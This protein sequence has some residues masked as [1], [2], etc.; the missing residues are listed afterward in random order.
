MPL[1]TYPAAPAR[2]ARRTSAG[3]SCMVTTRTG[4]AGVISLICRSTV[5]AVHVRQ[6]E[7]QQ[8]HFRGQV[9]RDANGF[10]L[11]RGFADDLDLLAA[12]HAAES[13]TDHQVIVHHEEPDRGLSRRRH[14]H[15][16]APSGQS[17][18]DGGPAARGRCRSGRCRRG[19]APAPASPPVR[20]RARTRGTAIAVEAHPVITHL[21][22][23]PALA[24]TQLDLHARAPSVPRGIEEAL[25]Q[26]AEGR[27][28][29]RRR[30]PRVAEPVDE[31]R[32]PSGFLSGLVEGEAHG[33]D[34]AD[35]VHGRGPQ[36]LQHPARLD[37]RPLESLGRLGR[38]RG[39]RDRD[40]WSRR[41]ARC[42]R[43]AWR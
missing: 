20:G 1:R 32:G 42:P 5:E 24:P 34:E 28:L 29:D 16:P 23:K 31:A 21:E 38:S 40:R 26:D 3:S 36:G 8:D 39:R 43:A 30:H 15:F 37:D 19:P 4:R 27:R 18:A 11:G 2:T 14:R 10:A 35:G 6:L 13:F 22:M 12:Q 7:I 33:L 17:H 41:L 25:L 9:R